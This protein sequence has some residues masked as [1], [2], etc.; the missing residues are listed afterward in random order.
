MSAAR[1]VGRVGKLAVALGVGAAVVAGSGV[2]HADSTS[3]ESSSSSSSDSGDAPARTGVNSDTDA[4]QETATSPPEEANSSEPKEAT[5]ADDP[6]QDASDKRKGR[7]RIWTELFGGHAHDTSSSAPADAEPEGTGDDTVAQDDA[8]LPEEVK[9]TNSQRRSADAGVHHS[10]SSR[11]PAEDVDDTRDAVDP[12]PA[13]STTEVTVASV[14][15]STATTSAAHSTTAD[16]EDSAPEVTTP[17]TEVSASQGTSTTTGP[18]ATLLT[19]LLEALGGSS[20]D[21]NSPLAWLVA[22]VARR[23]TTSEADTAEQSAVETEQSTLESEQFA[24]ATSFELNGYTIVA[25]STEYVTSFYGMFT[26]WPAFQGV[27][28]GEQEFAVVDPDTGETVGS[29]RA[30]VS[31]NNDVGLGST[32]VQLV[33]TENI[34]GAEGVGD[35]E[36]PPVGSVIAYWGNGEYYSLYAALPSEDGN[37]VTYEYV[38]PY[39]A[40]PLFTAYDAAEDLT[41]YTAFNRT[42]DTDDG[43]SMAPAT[44]NS[45][46]I[47]A[48]TGLPPLYTS[49]QGSQQFNVYDAETGEV[50]GSFMGNVTVTSDALGTYTEAVYVTETLSGE[51]GTEA[52]QTPPVGAVYNVIYFGSDDLYIIYTSKPADSG[53]VTSTKLVT[54]LGTLDLDIDFDASDPP[55][56]ES[57]QF[58][59]YTFVP[60]SEVEES[61]INGLPPREVIIQGYQQFDVYDADGNYLG[62]VDADVTTQ[63]DWSGNS[64]QAILVTNVTS[65]SAGTGEGEVPP[66]GSVFNANYYGDNGYGLAY[67]SMPDP[68]GDVISYEFVTPYGSIPLYTT[69][70]ASEGLA[71]Y[72]YDNPFTDNAEQATLTTAMSADGAALNLLTSTQLLCPLESAENCLTATAA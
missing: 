53:D 33:V 32:Y 42:I 66:V 3:T 27:V 50:V 68:D 62:S 13:S 40:I 58:G 26:N 57:Y 63:W 10:L 36:T 35:G 1:F 49:V 67:S 44:E 6:G 20:S 41:D 30:V 65:G 2:A 71:E 51:V 14:A 15:A 69:Y 22:A 24:S 61:G 25:T 52:G 21:S 64:S 55:D 56:R 23:E 4:G 34:S 43:Y 46:E 28:Q 39:F 70:N 9:E 48:V 45:A 16:R 17:T 31:N 47:S 38:T 8:A 72:E 12:E 11:Q 5:V 60:I 54:S 19:R 37:V 7:D 18:L 29:F 59:D